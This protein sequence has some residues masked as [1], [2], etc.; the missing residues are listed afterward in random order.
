MD[1]LEHHSLLFSDFCYLLPLFDRGKCWCIKKPH[2]NNRKL[3]G[4]LEKLNQARVLTSTCSEIKNERE[5]N[6]FPIST[7]T[8]SV[9]ILESK[10]NSPISKRESKSVRATSD[11]L[12]LKLL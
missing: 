8:L 12:G 5:V 9:S 6:Y 4:K 1:K 2:H 11:D 7:P 10:F 3:N